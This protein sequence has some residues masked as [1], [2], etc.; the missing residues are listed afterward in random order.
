[1]KQHKKIS[2]ACRGETITEALIS[3]LMVGLI[4]LILAGAV[5][6]A[7]RINARTDPKSAALRYPGEKQA[8]AVYVTVGSDE[9]VAA[10]WKTDTGDLPGYYYYEYEN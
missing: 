8:D 6:A 5:T 3:I 7:A 10:L 2:R 1:M 9:I 4:F